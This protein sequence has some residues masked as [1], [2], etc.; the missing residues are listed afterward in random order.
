VPV[1]SGDEATLAALGTLKFFSFLV[2]DGSA[3]VNAPS[4]PS[5]AE[6]GLKIIKISPVPAVI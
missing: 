1:L 6:I 4:G 2:F 3:I 5:Q